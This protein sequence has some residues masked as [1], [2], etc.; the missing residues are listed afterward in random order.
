MG[1][2]CKV[3][4]FIQFIIVVRSCLLPSFVHSPIYQLMSIYYVLG[5]LASWKDAK[6]H[7]TS[8]C[9]SVAFTLVRKLTSNQICKTKI[10]VEKQRWALSPIGTQW[11]QHMA[12]LRVLKMNRNQVDSGVW[13]LIEKRKGGWQSFNVSKQHLQNHLDTRWQI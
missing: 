6:S 4:F 13:R 12:G 5:V 8:L 1:D 10:E 11:A 9:F 2:K 7:K 3:V